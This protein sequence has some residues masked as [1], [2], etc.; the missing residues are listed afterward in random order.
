MDRK[1]KLIGTLDIASLS[2]IEIGALAFPLVH[3]ADGDITYVDFTDAKSLREKYASDQNVPIDKIVEVDAI[4]GVS[5]LLD[6]IKGRKVDYVVASH[7]IEHVPDL[8]GWLGELRDVL[9][10]SGVI[11]LAIPDKR[12]CLDILRNESSIADVLAANLIGARVPQPQQILDFALNTLTVDREKAW[13][14]PEYYRVQNCQTSIPSAIELAK[15]ALNGVY[16]DTHCWVFT[17]RSLA[18]LFKR[19]ALDGLIDFEC[20]DFYDTSPGDHEFFITMRPCK[21]IDKIIKSWDLIS[22][23]AHISIN[24]FDYTSDFPIA[25]YE[26]KIVKQP[27]AGRGKEDGWYLVKNGKKRWIQDA[28]RLIESGLSISQVIQIDSLAFNSIPED[29]AK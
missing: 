9:R 21:D 8:L 20:T 25:K 6:S 2:G 27:A 12:Y 28:S 3:K 29:I 17:P 5:T 19:L 11:K 1:K 22:Q 10:D 4:W 7:V 18:N 26:G 13:T 15:S 16:V 24:Q 23:S 14:D